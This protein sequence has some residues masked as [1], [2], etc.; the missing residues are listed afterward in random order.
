MVLAP[1]TCM[2]GVVKVINCNFFFVKQESYSLPV[3]LETIVRKLDSLLL[4]FLQLCENYELGK[5][6]HTEKYMTRL[7]IRD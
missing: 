7:L 4:S 5:I 3:L 2:E 6:I 1:V